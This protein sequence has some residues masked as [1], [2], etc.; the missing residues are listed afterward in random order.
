MRNHLG[1]HVGHCDDQ[2]PLSCR[3]RPRKIRRSGIRFADGE[4]AFV[5]PAFP[6]KALRVGDAE[7]QGGALLLS[8]VVKVDTDTVDARRHGEGDLEVG[9]VL[10]TRDVAL[11]HQVRLVSL[12]SSG[13]ESK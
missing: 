9:L 5:S 4:V 11:K 6:A 10:G 8:C 13:R 3:N 2:T 1:A 7:I 12:L